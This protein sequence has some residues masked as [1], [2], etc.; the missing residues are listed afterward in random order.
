MNF[1]LRV[2]SVFA[3]AVVGAFCFGAET[4]VEKTALDSKVEQLLGQMTLDEKIGQM[5]QVDSD[6]LKNRATDVGKYFFG[7]VLSGGG[8][9]PP[10]G[11]TAKDWADFY[12]S[13]QAEALKTRLKI[14]II[15]GIDAVHGHNNVDGAVLFPHNIGLGASR[16]PALA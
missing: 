6:A 14:P 8:S 16:N 1:L 4:V 12:D 3:I 9:D 7:S 10:G 13:F 2:A 11:N 5:T 15:Y